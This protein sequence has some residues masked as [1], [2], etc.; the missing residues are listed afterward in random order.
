MVGCE[1]YTKNQKD[2]GK[3]DSASFINY[4]GDEFIAKEMCCACGGGSH[5]KVSNIS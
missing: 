5:G 1:F 4:Y 3:Y 2:C